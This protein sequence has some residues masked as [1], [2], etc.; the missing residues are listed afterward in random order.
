MKN[1]ANPYFFIST[2]SKGEYK[3]VS[4]TIDSFSPKMESLLTKLMHSKY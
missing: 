3:F 4:L 1:N 2:R